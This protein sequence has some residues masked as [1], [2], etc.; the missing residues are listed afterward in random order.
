MEDYMREHQAIMNP[1][2]PNRE[3]PNRPNASP[4]TKKP[5]TAQIKRGHM[6]TKHKIKKLYK[7]RKADK[8]Y[9]ES[10]STMGLPKPKQQ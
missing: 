1:F 6:K 10:S 8:G 5:K 7:T 4:F 3:Y 9:S 2:A